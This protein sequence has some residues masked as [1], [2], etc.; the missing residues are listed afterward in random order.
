MV[1]EAE[2]AAVSEVAQLELLEVRIEAPDG[3]ELERPAGAFPASTDFRVRIKPAQPGFV[4]VVAVNPD[5]TYQALVTDR[6][7]RDA[8]GVVSNRLESGREFVFPGGGLPMRFRSGS[9]RLLIGF[10]SNRESVPQGLRGESLRTLSKVEVYPVEGAGRMG[11]VYGEAGW[12]SCRLATS[13][14]NGFHVVDVSEPAG[15]RQPE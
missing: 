10:A 9:E 6:P 4:Y 5:G 12:L 13:E 11:V 2:K 7:A 1:G 14:A 3:S 15:G 8:T